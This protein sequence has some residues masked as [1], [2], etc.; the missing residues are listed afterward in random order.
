MSRNKNVF[1]KL[2]IENDFNL[3]WPFSSGYGLNICLFYT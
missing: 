1:Q 3:V 2:D